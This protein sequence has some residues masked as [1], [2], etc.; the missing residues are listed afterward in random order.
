MSI[1][2]KLSKSPGPVIGGLVGKELFCLN[3]GVP[4]WIAYSVGGGAMLSKAKNNIADYVKTNIADI[5]T[6]NPD[7]HQQIL[8]SL[9]KPIEYATTATL[10]LTGAV[11]GHQAQKQLHK[12]PA[13]KSAHEKA[14]RKVVNSY[15]TA[16][17][18][19]SSKK[20]KNNR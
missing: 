7:I 17:N 20:D 5:Y 15:N 14:V 8:D 1:E 10:I 3:H 11:L 16:K 9:D 12:I 2:D 4:A 18:Y 19:V 13:I 6:Q